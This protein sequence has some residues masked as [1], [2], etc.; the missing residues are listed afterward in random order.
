[1][2]DHQKHE[3]EEEEEEIATPRKCSK[4]QGETTHQS[5]E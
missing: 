2:A 5:T 1:V 4:K 3:E